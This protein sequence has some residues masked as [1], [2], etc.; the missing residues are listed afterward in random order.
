MCSHDGSYHIREF[1]FL[2]FLQDRT[3]LTAIT[4]EVISRQATI[5]IGVYI[6]YDIFTYVYKVCLYTSVCVYVC[7]TCMY[8][9]MYLYVLY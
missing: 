3:T 7:A 2:L 4:P 6:V 8:I 1:P 9:H 5:N